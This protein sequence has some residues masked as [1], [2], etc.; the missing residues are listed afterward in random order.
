MPAV[1]QRKSL[2]P[3]LKDE[4]EYFKHQTDAI[5]KLINMKNFL[6]ADDMG[7]GKS[8]QS[9]TVHCIDVKMGKA[10]TCLIVCPVTLRDNWAEEIQKFTRIPY[11][12][13]GEEPH[14]TR[15]GETRKITGQKRH[16]QLLDW[17]NHQHGPRFLIVNYEQLTSAI[18]QDTFKKFTFDTVIY[19]EA[20]YLKNPDS[21]RTKASLDIQKNRA[22]L[23]TGTP[24]LNQVNELWTLLH[25]IDPERFPKYWSFV[26]RYCVFGGYEGRQIV[27]TKNEKE[28]V[29][30]LGQVMIRRMKD[31]VLDRDK[32]TYTQLYVGLSPEQ[33]RLYDSVADELILPPG[34]QAGLAVPAGEEE[35]GNALTKFLRLKQICGTPYAIDPSYPDSSFKLDRAVEIVKEFADRD[36]KI[37]VFTQFRGVLDA[38]SKRL[39]KA[40]AGPTFQLHG[41][42]PQKERQPLVGKW[43]RVSGAATMA[44]MTQVAGVGLNMVAASTVQFIDKLFVPGLNKQAV[45]RVD[46]IGQEKPVQVFELIARGTVEQ[47]VEDILKDKTKVNEEIVEGSVGMGKLLAALKE[48]MKHDLS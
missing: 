39:A 40:G 19:D 8:L 23:L 36:E 20:H 33:Q 27:G 43:G 15:K 1:A 22:M 2:E 41:D 48:R 4:I 17:M 28:L 18:H 11:L 29:T 13:F 42:V 45:D 46:R 10:E 31:Q 38:F 5:R 9:L 21:K 16:Q 24:M 14:P 7:L 35:I 25:M 44:C 6:L 30:V 32:P 47:R 26:N 3:F 34:V 12:L 37:V